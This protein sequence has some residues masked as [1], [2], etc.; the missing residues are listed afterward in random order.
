[1]PQAKNLRFKPFYHFKGVVPEMRGFLEGSENLLLNT[2]RGGIASSERIAPADSLSLQSGATQSPKFLALAP[3]FY[4]GHLP[5]RSFQIYSYI[6][7][8]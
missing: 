2:N 5:K 7:S 8:V 6:R 1:M 3:N 4:I